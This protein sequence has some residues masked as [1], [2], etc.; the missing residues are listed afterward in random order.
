MQVIVVGRG[1]L[2]IEYCPIGGFP[3]VSD[4]ASL[5]PSR[6]GTFEPIG[7]T[8]E[9]YGVLPKKIKG[10]SCEGKGHWLLCPKLRIQSSDKFMAFTNIAALPARFVHAD[11]DIDSRPIDIAMAVI[12]AYVQEFVTTECDCLVLWAGNVRPPDSV[13]IVVWQCKLDVH[14]YGA[15][16]V[17]VQICN[18]VRSHSPWSESPYSPFAGPMA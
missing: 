18:D 7:H 17:F 10:F 11:Q 1:R 14:S 2:S 8:G 15:P 16:L 9:G 4:Q 6:I 3:G 12:V 13:L 5:H